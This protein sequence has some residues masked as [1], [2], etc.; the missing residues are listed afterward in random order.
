MYMGWIFWDYCLQTK[1]FKSDLLTNA[2]DFESETFS[3]YINELEEAEK[4]INLEIFESILE[5]FRQNQHTYSTYQRVSRDQIENNKIVITAKFIVEYDKWAKQRGYST[6]RS[7]R[8]FAE[9]EST[10]LNRDIRVKAMRYQDAVGKKHDGK[11]IIFYYKEILALRNENI[12]IMFEFHLCIKCFHN[13][14]IK[15]YYP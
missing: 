13:L 9:L 12:L 7:M 6:L 3:N 15:N 5:F 11:G 1:S 4:E 10:L 2:L 8:E 14:V